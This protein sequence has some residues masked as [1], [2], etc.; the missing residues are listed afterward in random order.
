VSDHISPADTL[1]K[2]LDR[3]SDDQFYTRNRRSTGGE[4]RASKF[5]PLQSSAGGSHDVDANPPAVT[6]IERLGGMRAAQ[7]QQ[8]NAT[9]MDE[10]IEHGPFMAGSSFKG[11][12]PLSVGMCL[13]SCT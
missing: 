2:L 8:Y 1:V 9:A 7:S 13:P 5:E 6:E 3:F 12:L 11:K 4:A 10:D